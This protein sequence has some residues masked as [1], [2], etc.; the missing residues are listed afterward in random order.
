MSERL[1]YTLMGLSTKR[2]L[3]QLIAADAKDAQRNVGSIPFGTA[4]TAEARTRNAVAM[5]SRT[6]PASEALSLGQ[7]D[8]NYVKRW[9]T[10]C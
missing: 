3:S 9:R 7:H 2:P 1:Q 10:Q 8:A 6:A 4:K 5:V